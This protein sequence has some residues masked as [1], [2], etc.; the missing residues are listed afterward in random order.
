MRS[1][2]WDSRSASG[3]PVGAGLYFVRA[4]SDARVETTRFTILR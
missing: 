1:V 3:Q 2:T 4:S